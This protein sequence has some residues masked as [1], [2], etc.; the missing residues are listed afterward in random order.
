[1]G[2]KKKQHINDSHY[3]GLMSS[4]RHA[5]NRLLFFVLFAI[6]SFLSVLGTSDKMLY[7]ESPIQVPLLNIELP[8]LAFYVVMP[9][10][11]L[12]LTFNL[13]YTFRAHREFL[14]STQEHHR[15]SLKIIPLGL[16]EG[17]LLNQDKFHIAIRF[18]MRFVLYILP[19]IVLATFWFRFADYQHLLISTWHFIAILI[20]VIFSFSFRG[21]LNQKRKLCFKRKHAFIALSFSCLVLVISLFIYHFFIIYPLSK[22]ELALDN[23][24]SYDSRIKFILGKNYSH[25]EWF[26]PKITLYGEVLVPINKEQLEVLQEIKQH[27]K[28]NEVLLFS[29]PRL[30]KQ[31]RNFRK[32]VLNNCILPNTNFQHSQLQGANLI[33]T[34][35]QGAILIDA[36]LQGAILDKAQL[37]GADLSYTQLQGAHLYKAQ[38]QGTNL[39]EAQLQAT[40]LAYAQL[41]GADLSGA[42]LQGAFLGYTQLQGVNL[43]KAELQG[44]DLNNAQLQGANLFYTKLQGA[45]L[46]NTQLQ[47]ANLSNAQLQGASSS[48]NSAMTTFFDRKRAKTN[49]KNIDLTI[50]EKNQVKIVITSLHS[51]LSKSFTKEDMEKIKQR[52]Q[53]AI[54]KD[55]I[56]WITQQKGIILG[57]LYEYDFNEIAKNVTEPEARKRM[58]LPPP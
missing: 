45:D 32:I 20:S 41:Q 40:L 37:Q 22:S 38:L 30:D 1:M 55:P 56:E 26:I 14:L 21:L 39:I 33:E 19:I 10:F 28:E 46:N 23:I 13:L 52:L 9:L 47:G 16:Y 4:M 2:K 49:I 18:I 15:A 12:V 36:Q 27:K 42:Q 34:Q 29:T 25:R 24:K 7:L 51:Y 35:L 57:I 11:I 53:K 43:T 54:G 8:L 48:E 17:A 6:Y 44:A 50:L 5:R 58:G 31:N 3:E